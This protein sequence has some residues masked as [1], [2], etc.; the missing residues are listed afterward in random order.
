MKEVIASILGTKV[1]AQGVLEGAEG[2]RI[3]HAA[4]GCDGGEVGIGTGNYTQLR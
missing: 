3:S 2:L 1:L 4:R